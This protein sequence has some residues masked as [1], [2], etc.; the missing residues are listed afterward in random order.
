MV[1][2]HLVARIQGNQGRARFT[3]GLLTGSVLV[4]TVA[5]LHGSQ[6]AKDRHLEAANFQR[7]LTQF[8]HELAQVKR[9]RDGLGLKSKPFSKPWQTAPKRPRQQPAP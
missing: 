4:G 8:N 3:T 1:G 5:T 2:A 7:R 6:A 9:V